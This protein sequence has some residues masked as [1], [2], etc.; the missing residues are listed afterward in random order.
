[1]TVWLLG[2]RRDHRAPGVGARGDPV[3]Q[4]H[5]RPGP[6]RVVRDGVAVEAQLAPLQAAHAAATGC[7]RDAARRLGRPEGAASL[8]DGREAHERPRVQGDDRERDQQHD[9]I[10]DERQPARSL[11]R[12]ALE[13]LLVA[14]E[15]ALER[16]PRGHLLGRDR[17]VVGEVDRHAEQ[18]AAVVEAELRLPVAVDRDRLVRAVDALADARQAVDDQP[19]ALPGGRGQPLGVLRGLRGIDG[20]D[21]GRVAV[22]VRRGRRAAGPSR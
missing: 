7:V 4:Q 5:D 3:D 21:R 20:H 13:D 8:G 15:R 1:M 12:L 10:A 19:A 11:L 17:R 2:E 14:H 22:G 6:R 18:R 16:G 9:R